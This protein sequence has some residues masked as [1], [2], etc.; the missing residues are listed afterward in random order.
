MDWKATGV[1]YI[2]P[3]YDGAPKWGPC[4]IHQLPPLASRHVWRAARQSGSKDNQDVYTV[5]RA[6]RAWSEAFHY[7]T[8]S[9]LWEQVCLNE[10]LE[11]PTQ[12][13]SIVV[14]EVC[15]AIIHEYKAEVLACPNT[16]EGWRSI[17]DKF[18]GRW[19]LPHT[20]RPL[21]GK[22]VACCSPPGSRSLYFNC[23]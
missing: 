21:D 4:I 11:S 2:R 3:A 17:S 13:Y 5:Q 18:Y 23:K 10:G 15:L 8:S 20:L 9:C 12:H 16:H 22:H 7:L 1:R 6:R 19:N 14:R